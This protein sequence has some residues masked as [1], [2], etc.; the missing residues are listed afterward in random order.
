MSVV[1]AGKSRQPMTTDLRPLA[2]E[3]DFDLLVRLNL[4]EKLFVQLF[5]SLFAYPGGDEEL[6]RLDLACRDVMAKLKF[7]RL[8]TPEEQQEYSLHTSLIMK[9]LISRID[10]QRLRCISHARNASSA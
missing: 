2:S 6:G 7:P 10:D 1:Q 5:G 8:L 3:V 4:Y 9:T